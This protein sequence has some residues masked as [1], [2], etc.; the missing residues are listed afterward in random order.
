MRVTALETATSCD[1]K[2][3]TLGQRLGIHSHWSELCSPNVRS[4]K[5][6]GNSRVKNRHVSQEKKSE[7]SR[8]CIK[9]FSFHC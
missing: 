5:I 9:I 1:L 3:E 6:P 4:K 2:M 7:Y 8:F